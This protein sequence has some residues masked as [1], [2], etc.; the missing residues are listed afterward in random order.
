M[1]SLVEDLLDV[2][3]QETTEYNKLY[4]FAQSKR[5]AIVDRDLDF[6]ERVTGEEQICSNNLKNL[7]NKR[8]RL[9]KDMSV[10]LGQD[11][12]LLSVTQVIEMLQTQPKEQQDLA[13]ARD[14]L[15]KSATRMQFLN[16]QIQALLRQ[17]LEMVEFD[18]TL[19]KSLKQAPETAN[20][21]RNA[22]NTGDLL[23][24]GGFDAKQ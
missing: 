20:Y 12:Q 17:S 24:D 16:Q 7:E 11:D 4:E 8:L 3:S 1:A 22:S 6:L 15:V 9:L 10:V 19:Y 21:D 14:E 2:L 18:L 13:S 5:K 23:G